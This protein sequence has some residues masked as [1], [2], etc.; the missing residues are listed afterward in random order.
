MVF[1]YLMVRI[2]LDEGDSCE[3]F[4]TISEHGIF[5]GIG[6]YTKRNSIE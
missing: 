4:E 1:G 6:T 2:G 5:H 3:R